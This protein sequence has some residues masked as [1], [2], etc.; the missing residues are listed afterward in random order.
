MKYRFM[1][2]HHQ[3]FSIARMSQIFKVS[4][5]GY[6]DWVNR[7]ISIRAQSNAKL[8][9]QI[10]TVHMSSRESYG[11]LK[12]THALNQ[13]GIVCGKNRVARLRQLHGIETKRRKR[14]KVTTHSKHRHWIAE[15]ILDREFI[16]DKPNKVWVGDVTFIATRSGWLYLAVML[17]LYSRKVVGWSM[18]NRN[19]QALVTD[20]LTMAIATR[21]PKAGLLHHTDRGR[22]Y[23]A[24]G[25]R[26]LLAKQRMIPSMSRKK[27]CWDNA[28]AESFF[29]NLKNEV[30]HYQRYQTRE[31]AKTA[32]FDYI[33]IFYNRQRIHQT[34]NYHSPND[35]EIMNAA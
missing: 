23:A 3:E 21:K 32:I 33:E 24:H 17:D 9:A 5:S 16:V 15:N 10:K 2:A 14:F 1:Q 31:E 30:I 25:Y 12:V 20:A 29:N 28:V 11:T 19:D 13:Q 26:A 22:L 7:P 6:Y 35:F 34:L 4:R 27:N 8:L 18:S